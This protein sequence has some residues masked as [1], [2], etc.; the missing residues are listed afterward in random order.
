MELVCAEEGGAFLARN[1]GIE[2]ATG[3]IVLFTDADCVV[4]PGWVRE[5]IA[6]IESGADLVQGYSGRLAI[7]R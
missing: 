5:A 4:A 3:A 6:G 2:R 1:R 7:R